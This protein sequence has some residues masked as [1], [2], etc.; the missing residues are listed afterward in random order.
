MINNTYLSSL[1]YNLF[2]ASQKSCQASENLTTWH[3]KL[4]LNIM[5]V[6]VA[7]LCKR[8]SSEWYIASMVKLQALMGCLKD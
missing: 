2:Q 3:G 4:V 1:C 8:A 7:S 5:L 6:P